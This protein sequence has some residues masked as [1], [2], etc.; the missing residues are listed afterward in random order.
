[1]VD[2][3]EALAELRRGTDEILVDAEL[4]ERLQAGR[5]LRIKAGFD[6]TAPDLHLGHTVL[7]NKLRQFQDLGHD[8]YFLIGDFTGMIG[9]PSGKNVTR[10]PLSAEEVADNA[11]TYEEQVFRILDRERTHVVF[12]SSWMNA[13]S[14]TDMIR[15]AARQTV[16]RMLERDDFHK[17]YHAGQSIAIHEFLYPLIQGYDSVELKADVELGGTDQKFNLLVGRQLQ[18]AY[19]QR[20]QVVIT[21][22]LLEGL[23]GV[24]KMSKSLDNYVGIQEPADEMFGKL[25]SISDELMWRYF[26]LLSLRPVAERDQLRKEAAEGRNP[27][28]IKFL[29]AEELVERFHDRAAGVRARE[30][31]LARF[32]RGATPEDMPE[33][34]VAARGGT[35]PI[36]TLLR[37][38]GLVASSSDGQ[39]MVRQGAVRIDGERVEDPS[40]TVAAGGVYVLQVGKR[41]FARV[42]VTG[43]SV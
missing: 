30:N 15:L 43:E 14:A 12:N 26:D 5:P 3:D 22:P 27:R 37:L 17:R 28:D 38:C 42:T 24:Q 21:V 8:L 16:A 10:K 33:E 34:T 20:P 31:F 1:M 7:I 35:V 18:H 23:D 32:Q 6:P 29:L 2:V 36:A 13:F 40:R 11:R 19:G 39:R 25:M 4:R 9:D 41:R